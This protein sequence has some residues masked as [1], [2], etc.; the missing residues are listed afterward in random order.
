M[1]AINSHSPQAPF[2]AARYLSLALPA[3]CLVMAG[4]AAQSTDYEQALQLFRQGR[5][6]EAN[7]SAEKAVGSDRGNAA[8]L[9]LYGLT[10]SALNRFD[11]A[12]ANLRKAIG[13][14]PKN[15]GIHN[16]FAAVLLRQGKQRQALRSLSTGRGW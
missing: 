4:A 7:R 14:L 3:F 1:S 6:Q 10:L 2:P 13:M 5:Y 11:E 9:H 15:A 16:D 12:E 8:Y